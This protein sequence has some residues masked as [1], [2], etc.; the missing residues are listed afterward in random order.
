MPL[1]RDCPPEKVC[2]IRPPACASFGVIHPYRVE[3]ATD[4]RQRVVCAVF[5]YDTR[6]VA[7]Q[8]WFALP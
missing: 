5:G 8:R 2:P 1:G 7:W 3:S 4:R 6:P